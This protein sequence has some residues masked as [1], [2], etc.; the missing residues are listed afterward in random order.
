MK[1]E[2]LLRKRVA[3]MM[4]REER[5]RGRKQKRPVVAAI[6]SYCSVLDPGAAFDTRNIFDSPPTS[7]RSIFLNGRYP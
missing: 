7:E 2:V 3:T 5:K 1:A 6:V 4:A